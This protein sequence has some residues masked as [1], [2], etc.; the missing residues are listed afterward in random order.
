MSRR[1]TIITN[2]NQACFRKL[3]PRRLQ[4]ESGEVKNHPQEALTQ[5]DPAFKV[6]RAWRIAKK[7]IV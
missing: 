7:D 5:L 2:R 3:A 1:K 4:E 6:G